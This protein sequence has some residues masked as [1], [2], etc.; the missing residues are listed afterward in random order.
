MQAA[1]KRSCRGKPHKFLEMEEE[2]LRYA[3]QVWNDGF[4]LYAHLAVR[5][6]LK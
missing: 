3:V 5:F 1:K 2:L 4:A 6:Q